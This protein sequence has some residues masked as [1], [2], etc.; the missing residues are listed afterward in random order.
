MTG[1]GIASYAADGR[2]CTVEVKSVNHRFL[3]VSVRAPRALAFIEDIIRKAIAA[4]I[5]R[6]HVDVFVN[7]HNDREDART[8]IMDE[9]LLR[10]YLRAF[11]SAA[12]VVIQTGVE[13][14][15]VVRPTLF[16]LSQIPELMRTDS[17]PEDRTAV[18][19]LC[20][21]ALG[22]ALD[23]LTAMRETEGAALRVDMNEHLAE[24]DGL[25][26]RIEAVAPMIISEYRD[27]LRQRIHDAIDS[28][29][30]PQRLDAGMGRNSII[31][32]ASGTE[33]PLQMEVA[34]LADRA[35]IDE[36]L[37]RLSSHIDQMRRMISSDQ[38]VGR[39]LD[40]LVQE[41]NREINTIGSKSI[42][43][44]VTRLVVDSK[45]EIEKLREQI[46]NI[47]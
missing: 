25:R 12:A 33:S 11:D 38:L 10:A 16:E 43:S 18:T 36:E 4:R 8:V 34:I 40:F 22:E 9:P 2:E 23:E 45:S 29:Y 47:E 42:N 28:S 32:G 7:Y 30:D 5:A 3:D 19:E 6:G 31:S 17:A 21:H 14:S 46:Q 41:L 13:Q 15:A 20:E 35:A 1:Y 39:K 24:L 26:A 44:D 37:T 27:K